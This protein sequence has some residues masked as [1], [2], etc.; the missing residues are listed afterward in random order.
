MGSLMTDTTPIQGELQ[1]QIMAVIW[2][3]ESGTVD[4]IRDGLPARYRGAYTTV[5]TVLNRLVERGLLTR[6]RSGRSFVYA[7]KLTEA[8]YLSRSMTRAFEGASSDARHAALAQFVGA[9]RDDELSELKHL[10]R[11]VSDARKAEET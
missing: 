2:R 7:P 9:L 3:A 8:E 5:Q 4:Q 6:R 10:T 1:V 11:R